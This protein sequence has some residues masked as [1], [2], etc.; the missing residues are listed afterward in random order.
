VVPSTYIAI[1]AKDRLLLVSGKKMELAEAHPVW[2][3]AWE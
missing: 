1:E 2:T 3:G